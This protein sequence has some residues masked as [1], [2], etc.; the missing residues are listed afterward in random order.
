MS[1]KRIDI[2]N[3][4]IV[5]CAIALMSLWPILSLHYSENQPK[6]TTQRYI[7]D[8]D[9]VA[10]ACKP[11]QRIASLSLLSDSILMHLVNLDRIMAWSKAAP[12]RLDRYRSNKARLSRN[13]DLEELIAQ[14]PDLV[15]DFTHG[16]SNKAVKRLREADIPVID[17]GN[18]YGIQTFLQA[19][20]KIADLVDERER[21][22]VFIADFKYRLTLL[23][24]AH[25]QTKKRALHLNV[26]NGT[27]FGGTTGTCYYDVFEAAGVIDVAAEAGYTGW[28][29][30]TAD[31]LIILDPPIIITHVGGAEELRNMPSMQVLSAVKNNTI[32]EMEPGLWGDPGYL[33]IEA[34][35]T[36]H[37]VIYTS[38]EQM[39]SVKDRQ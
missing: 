38:D 7:R 21:G 3:T 16:T 2:G 37:R 28:P 14:G 24:N 22:A 6:D 23:K 11:Y 35:E 15:I 29:Q 12:N 20:E 36:L 39:L 13:D 8:A 27:F 25:P 9:N 31:E 32:L 34:A 4:I 19:C 33:M 18:G 1:I 5:L 17:L 30:Y 10:V 26:Y